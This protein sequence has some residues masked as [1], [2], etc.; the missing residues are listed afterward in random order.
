MTGS[1]LKTK[2]RF[3]ET[4]TTDDVAIVRDVAGP[5]GP[6]LD[7]YAGITLRVGSIYARDAATLYR[8]LQ[9]V[10]NDEVRRDAAESDGQ[11]PTWV[12]DGEE[13]EALRLLVAKIKTIQHESVLRRALARTGD[14]TI[15]V[16]GVPPQGME[17]RAETWRGEANAGRR[18]EA[19]REQLPRRGGRPIGAT[20]V[21]ESISGMMT[22]DG[23]QIVRI[24]RNGKL[25]TK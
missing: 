24:D 22:I 2:V 23:E 17:R 3:I 25:G 20:R 5:Y 6:L 18:W 7:Q 8:I 15:I 21:P 1:G 12:N 19:I 11:F 16:P 4:P 14:R 10:D 13:E 9:C